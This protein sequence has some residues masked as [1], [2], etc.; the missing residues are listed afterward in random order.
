M[1]SGVNVDQVTDIDAHIDFHTVFVTVRAFLLNRLWCRPDVY[2]DL[3]PKYTNDESQQGYQDHEA[4]AALELGHL[5]HKL[6]WLDFHLLVWPRFFLHLTC[7]LRLLIRKL[8]GFWLLL[9]STKRFV[10]RLLD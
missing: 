4:D 1:T 7:G 3:D 6:G 5:F 10:F 9:H 2:G 8:S